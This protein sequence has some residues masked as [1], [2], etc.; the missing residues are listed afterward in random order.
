M[1]IIGSSSPRLSCHVV[2][3]SKRCLSLPEDAMVATNTGISRNLASDILRC[4]VLSLEDNEHA[5]LVG[6]HIDPGMAFGSTDFLRR[7]P[8]HARLVRVRHQATDR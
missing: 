5:A 2:C 8:R 7:R 4:Y 3:E 6:G 1:S